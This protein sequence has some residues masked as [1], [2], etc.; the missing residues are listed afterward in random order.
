ML[1]KNKKNKIVYTCI[2][3]FY[4]VISRQN[5][6]HEEYDYICFTDNKDYLKLKYMYGWRFLPLVVDRF[7]NN[8]NN[9]WHKLH[10]HLLFPDYEICIYIDANVNILSPYLFEVFE[11]SGKDFMFQRHESC[12]C[13]YEEGARVKQLQKDSVENVD[14]MLELLRKEKMPKNYGLTE[15][16]IICSR[17]TP[18]S[19]KMFD[20]WW[21]FLENYCC[22][23]QMSLAYVLWKSGIKVEDIALPNFRHKNPDVYAPFGHIPYLPLKQR[24]FGCRHCSGKDVFYVC[25]L[26]LLT[27]KIKSDKK[28][29]YLAGIKWFSIKQR[30]GGEVF[31]LL[32]FIPV[33]SKKY[34]REK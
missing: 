11:K 17:N 25:F 4:D 16:N 3:G 10:P 26:P 15:N 34:A 19:R 21:P 5:Y 12:S 33:W 18:L 29:F 20:E 13:I 2:C 30:P 22:R 31:Y 7:N 14:K 24:I 6:Q 1:M 32:G 28:M 9:R 8:L 23:D 27:V